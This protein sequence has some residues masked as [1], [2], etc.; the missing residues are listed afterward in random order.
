MLRLEAQDLAAEQVDR[1]Q[2]VVADGAEQ[3]F[4][5]LV[6]PEDGVGQVELDDRQPP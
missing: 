4:V 6:A 1:R 3:L 5:A 2:I